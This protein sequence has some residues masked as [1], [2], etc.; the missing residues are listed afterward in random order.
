MI[1]AQDERLL[2]W[3]HRRW[4]GNQMKCSGCKRRSWAWTAPIHGTIL[5]IFKPGDVDCCVYSKL[6]LLFA[7]PIQR[8][9]Q[10]PNRRPVKFQIPYKNAIHRSF[11]TAWLASTSS[12]LLLNFNLIQSAP[13]PVDT[14]GGPCLVHCPSDQYLVPINVPCLP[15]YLPHSPPAFLQLL[16]PLIIS[17]AAC[18]H[19][20]LWW[21]HK[22]FAFTLWTFLNGF[23]F[24]NGFTGGPF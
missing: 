2:R 15:F 10:S 18:F 6:P 24:S 16:L 4:L 5:N 1:F 19:S 21:D 20:M 12:S 23:N 3:E 17:P 7:P 9:H 13:P 14:R 22:Y 8:S 11:Y